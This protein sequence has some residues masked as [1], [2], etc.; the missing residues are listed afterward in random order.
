MIHVLHV[1]PIRDLLA[2]EQFFFQGG[3]VLLLPAA[4]ELSRQA[5][6]AAGEAGGHQIGDAA[7]FEERGVLHVEEKRLGEANDFP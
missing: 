6:P 1:V 7:R 5:L 2:V 4:H 3:P